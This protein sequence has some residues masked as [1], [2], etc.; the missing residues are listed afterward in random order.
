MESRL[1]LEA[2]RIHWVNALLSSRNCSGTP[3]P[4]KYTRTPDP[5]DRQ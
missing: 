5:D 1:S 3:F 2:D 4:W